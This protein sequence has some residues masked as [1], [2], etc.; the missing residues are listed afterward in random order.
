MDM[1]T[2]ANPE[3]TYTSAPSGSACAALVVTDIPD[4]VLQSARRWGLMWGG[5][6][7]TNRCRTEP[8]R[9]TT[10]RRDPHHF[11]FRGSPE[12]AA[13]IA[14]YNTQNP[15][16]P[17]TTTPATTTPGTTAPA[18]TMPASTPPATTGGTT[19]SRQNLKRGASGA[20]VKELQQL[21]SRNGVPT[22]ADGVFGPVTERNVRRFQTIR[23]LT[24]DGIVSDVVWAALESS[25]SAADSSSGGGPT[26]TPATTTPATTIPAS[27]NASSRPTISRGATGEAVV[28][29]TTELRKRGYPVP[30]S[31]VFGPRTDAAVRAFQRDNRLFIDGIVGKRT[32]RALGI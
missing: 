14:A 4:W 12:Q 5:Y 26:T 8:E 3:R 10:L 16:A 13:A 6:G 24:V 31:D 29:L 2:V 21:L 17:A 27:P 1:N 32:W 15:A 19:P 25:P 23:K 22:R 18:T 20:I 30:V 28:L 9:V 11:E 7:W